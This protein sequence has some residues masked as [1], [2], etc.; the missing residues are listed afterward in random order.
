MSK[1]QGISTYK[2][3]Q[4]ALIAMKTTAL[5]TASSIFMAVLGLIFTFAPDEAMG[6]FTLEPTAFVLLLIQ[7]CGAMYLGFAML[8]WM[9]RS[10]LVGGIYNRPVVVGNL[11]HFAMV[12]LVLLRGILGGHINSVFVIGICFYAVFAVWFGLVLFTH[13]VKQQAG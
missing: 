1:P 3:W 6:Y 8:N 7:V 2:S 12:T 9:V 4:T 10:G 5:M 11:L 13:P